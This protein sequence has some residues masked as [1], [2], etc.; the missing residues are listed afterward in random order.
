MRWGAVGAAVERGDEGALD[1]RMLVGVKRGQARA[2]GGGACVCECV[3]VCV[4][5]RHSGREYTE[6]LKDLK[7]VPAQVSSSPCLCHLNLKECESQSG[8][9]PYAEIREAQ[10]ARRFGLSQREEEEVAMSL[11]LQYFV[12][13][14][15]GD[16]GD[17]AFGKPIT[18]GRSPPHCH[19]HRR[20]GV[21]A[22]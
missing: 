22:W 5:Q 7:H 2:G 13:E 21:A 18:K 9:P 6:G 19:S 12:K 10:G 15:E 11:G 1:V 16:S 4:C 17:A 3:K 14:E 8:L 20:G